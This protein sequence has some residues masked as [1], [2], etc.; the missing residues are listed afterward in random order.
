MTILHIAAIKNNPYNGVCV[1]VPQHIKAQSQYAEVALLNI[2]NEILDDLPAQYVYKSQEKLNV[3]PDKFKTP[4]IVIFHEVYHVEYLELMKELK[5]RNIPYVIIPHGCL[6]KEA[7]NKKRAKKIIGNLLLFN[8]FISNAVAIQCLSQLELQNTRFNNTKFIGTNGV[9]IPKEKKDKFSNVGL[10]FVYIGR[11]EPY[12]KGLDL[13]IQA[14]AINADLLREH[15][16]TFNLY[17]PDYKGWFENVVDMIKT[18]QVDDFVFMNHEIS[19]EDKKRILLDSDIFIQTSR[20]EGMPMGIL[21][22]LS[23]GIPCIVTQGTNLREIIEENDAGWGADN[24]SDSIGDAIKH[25]ISNQDKLQQK[26]ENA[27]KLIKE[28]FEWSVVAKETIQKYAVLM[29]E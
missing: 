24:T 26:S 29:N 8:R 23:Y 10:K 25:F 13:L 5:K 14:I 3:L 28:K 17:G 1:V 19:G 9:I 15:K 16:C 7:Q 27:I 12:I 4:D 2:N 20:S 6:T 21:E 18:N 11:M 22:A